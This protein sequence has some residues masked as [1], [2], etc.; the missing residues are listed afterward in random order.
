MMLNALIP[1]AQVMFGNFVQL[2]TTWMVLNPARP[3]AVN[4]LE[5]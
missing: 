3:P 2:R 1:R 4:A 5:L